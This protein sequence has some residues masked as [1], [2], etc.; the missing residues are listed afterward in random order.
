MLPVFYIKDVSNIYKKEFHVEGN[1]EIE[2]DAG[3]IQTKY[4]SESELLIR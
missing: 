1:V 3:K 4:F 2:D